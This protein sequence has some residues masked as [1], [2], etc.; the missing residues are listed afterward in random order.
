MENAGVLYNVYTAWFACGWPVAVNRA[1]NWIILNLWSP[2]TYLSAKRNCCTA[3]VGDEAGGE[4]SIDMETLFF[5]S[6]STNC[7]WE[8]KSNN[9]NETNRLSRAASFQLLSKRNDGRL[10]I[11]FFFLFRKRNFH[12]FFHE[13]VANA[14]SLSLS[15]LNCVP[16]TS[17]TKTIRK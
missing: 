7:W 8:R 17:T 4:T 12:S 3:A 10:R 6:I 15:H 2:V 14:I 9:L 1:N 13:Y 11:S 5:I 16:V